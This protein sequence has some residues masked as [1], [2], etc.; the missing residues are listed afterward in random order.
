LLLS[1][2]PLLS[3]SLLARCRAL[4]T[5]HNGPACGRS[6][7]SPAR[8]MPLEEDS[9]LWLPLMTTKARLNKGEGNTGEGRG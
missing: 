8:P 1:P 7:G 6:F 9:A 3:S 4:L 5:G 2:S